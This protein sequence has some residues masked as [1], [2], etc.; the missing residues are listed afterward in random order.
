MRGNSDF[1][2]GNYGGAT[3]QYKRAIELDPKNV[4]LHCNIATVLYKTGMLVGVVASAKRGL[5]LK[6][7]SY[8]AAWRHALASLDLFN[9]HGCMVE[10]HEGK[11]YLDVSTKLKAQ[12]DENKGTY[13]PNRELDRKNRDVLV[14]ISA[15]QKYSRRAGRAA[16]GSLGQNF[17]ALR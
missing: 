8:K 10:L 11:H 13:I 7:N 5:V 2:R 16:P 17:H 6:P 14:L 4:D 3:S 9:K 15:R 12:M 1:H